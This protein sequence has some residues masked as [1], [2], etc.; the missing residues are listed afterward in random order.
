VVGGSVK[1][2]VLAGDVPIDAG[3]SAAQPVR[4]GSKRQCLL[5][6]L[7]EQ[8]DCFR[9]HRLE[10]V[11][12]PSTR[13]ASPA[14]LLAVSLGASCRAGVGTRAGRLGSHVTTPLLVKLPS[15]RTLFYYRTTFDN[16]TSFDREERA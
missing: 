4:Q 14:A 2:L 15:Y 6:G 5:T 1:Q 7:V 3:D 13:W 16:R 10:G 9:E 8:G 12:C 11:G